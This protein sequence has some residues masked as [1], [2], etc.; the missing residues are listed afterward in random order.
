MSLEAMAAKGQ[1]KLARKAG[2]MATS[3]SASKG[4]ASQNFSAVGFGPARTAAY[5]AGIEAATYRAPDPVKW[6]ANWLAKMRE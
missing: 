1:A 2:Q 6:A 4:R 3:Y 5:R